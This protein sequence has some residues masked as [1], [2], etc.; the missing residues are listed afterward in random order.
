MRS[1]Q[2]RGLRFSPYKVRFRSQYVPGVEFGRS[3]GEDG[4]RIFRFPGGLPGQRLV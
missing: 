3:L 2:W 4:G 1:Y